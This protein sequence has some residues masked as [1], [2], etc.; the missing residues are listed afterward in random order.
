[1]QS[2]PAPTAITSTDAD[3]EPPEI[4]PDGMNALDIQASA[5]VLENML[6]CASPT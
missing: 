6:S 1:M 4:C 2:E 3:Q 5:L